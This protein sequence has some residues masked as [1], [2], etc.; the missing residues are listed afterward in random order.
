[1]DF[2]KYMTW[3]SLLEKEK[4]TLIC[5]CFFLLSCFDPQNYLLAL[6]LF[7]IFGSHGFEKKYLIRNLQTQINSVKNKLHIDI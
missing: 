4:L 1:M 6:I 7:N 5:V 3:I 2:G